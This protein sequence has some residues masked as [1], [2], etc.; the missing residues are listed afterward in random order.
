MPVRKREEVQEVLH[1][2][3]AE[4][5][6][7]WEGPL[8]A[9]PAANAT[10]PQRNRVRQQDVEDKEMARKPAKQKELD[11][12]LPI[13]QIKI[14]LRHTEPL[15]WRRVQIDDCSLDELHEIIQG[16]MIHVGKPVVIPH[17]GPHG[18]NQQEA[19]SPL[20]QMERSI[21]TEC[22]N[23]PDPEGWA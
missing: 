8:I 23:R 13:Y 4:L 14:S 9:S 20:H 5:T 11:P 2:E 19:R 7:G 1:E 17:G 15:I 12:T 10:C 3:A 6:Q 18:T 22:Q 21:P 16:T